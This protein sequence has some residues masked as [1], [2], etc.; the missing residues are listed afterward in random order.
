[1][2]RLSSGEESDAAYRIGFVREVVDASRQL[3]RA[4]E[5][6]SWLA[7]PA[8]LPGRL[9]RRTGTPR[10]ALAEASQE[11][12]V[13]DCPEA[14]VLC[15]SWYLPP[16]DAPA[17]VSCAIGSR[18]HLAAHDVTTRLSAIIRLAA[19]GAS[20]SGEAPFVRPARRSGRCEPSDRCPRGRQTAA[21]PK[22]AGPS[23]EVNAPR[24]EWT[25]FRR[26]RAAMRRCGHDDSAS[27]RAKKA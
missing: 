2:R 16:N 19:G 4:I 27:D 6:P 11:G 15:R 7:L 9:S 23:A 21:A 13:W 25:R 8:G 1:M 22:R 26:N 24:R 12:P 3:E 14:N 20:T 5:L 10:K 17:T 18:T